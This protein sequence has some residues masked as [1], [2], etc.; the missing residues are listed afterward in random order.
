M[1]QK[2]QAVFPGARTAVEPSC[3]VLGTNS[4]FLFYSVSAV[5]RF[6]S[7]PLP[8][9]GGGFV[10]GLLCDLVMI[11]YDFKDLGTTRTVQTQQNFYVGHVDR[12]D[13]AQRP[14]CS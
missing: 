12:I 1:T 13:R 14:H 4:S 7:P 2:F 10:V 8:S 5:S 3:G 6:P 9:L 11:H